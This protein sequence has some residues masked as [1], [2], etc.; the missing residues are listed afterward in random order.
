MGYG[1]ST[2]QITLKLYTCTS[3]SAETHETDYYEY[4]NTLSQKEGGLYKDNFFLGGCSSSSVSA[5][6]VS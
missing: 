6:V 5:Q 2:T 4:N 3:S 1:V